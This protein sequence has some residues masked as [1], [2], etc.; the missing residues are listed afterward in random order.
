MPTYIVPAVLPPYLTELYSA[1]SVSHYA[2]GPKTLICDR[3]PVLTHR[4][5]KFGHFVFI[6]TSISYKTKVQG[7]L[8]TYIVS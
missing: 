5:I 3:V 6:H 2:A 7:L 1:P 4:L 8:M